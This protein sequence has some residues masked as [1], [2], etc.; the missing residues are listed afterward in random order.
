M[1][2]AAA[3]LLRQLHGNRDR[4]IYIYIYVYI[5]KQLNKQ[6]YKQKLMYINVV[7]VHIYYLA[8]GE[9]YG[10]MTTHMAV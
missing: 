6:I 3:I 1:K 2:H 4:H 10:G 9:G 8:E 5:L 7:C